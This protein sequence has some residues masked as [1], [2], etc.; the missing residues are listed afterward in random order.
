MK[1]ERYIITSSEE[2][3]Y[4]YAMEPEDTRAYLIKLVGLDG[5]VTSTKRIHAKNFESAYNFAKSYVIR[6]NFD[7][8]FSII[9]E[10]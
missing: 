3:L 5:Y 8:I 4:E 7:R 2:E 10:T 9:E 1:K 6:G